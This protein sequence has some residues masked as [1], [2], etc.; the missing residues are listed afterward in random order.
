MPEG[1]YLEGG[2]RSVGA[3][4]MEAVL[5]S[6]VPEGLIAVG[7]MLGTYALFGLPPSAPLLTLAFCGTFLVYQTD[8]LLAPSAEDVVNRPGRVAWARRH[9]GY[10]WGAALA[11]AAAGAAMLPWLRPSTIL[12]G[13]AVGSLGV[14][15]VAPLLPGR[16]RLKDL[17]PFKPFFIALAWGAGSV[18]LPVV[19]AGGPLT[20]VAGA[21]VPYRLLFILP[22]VLL[23]D[24]ADRAGDRAAGLR[25]V[26][27]EWPWRRWRAFGAASALLA[28]MG[29]GVAVWSFGGPRLL[30]IDAV[31]PLL[32]AGAALR[33][34]A[35][36]R[37]FYGFV[38]DAIVGW[39]AV[40]A[41]WA[42]LS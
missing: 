8:R 22:N 35:R 28:A 10:A 29:A 33:P 3:V 26:A 25:S 31:G 4:L 17:G 15:H 40:T 42:W 12:W 39:P 14:L 23:A 21:A 34:P 18:V 2:K 16:R 13:V 36:S 37:L 9:R 19:E 20:V 30:L 38:I 5:Y 6:N 1:A 41:L 24:W 27:S 7:L 11:T 32:M